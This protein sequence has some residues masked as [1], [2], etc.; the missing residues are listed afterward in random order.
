MPPRRA[1]SP[2]RSAAVAAAALSSPL[3]LPC[4]VVL[5]NRL[6]KAAMTEAL[7]D[8]LGR[9]TPELCRLYERWSA[10]GAGLLI[11]GNIQVDRRYVERPGNVAIDGG[12]N[13]L[14]GE[15]NYAD[16]M[17]RKYAASAKKHGSKVFAQLSHAGRQ[18]T[19]LI[20]RHP[21]GPGD[22]P[23]TH[24]GVPRAVAGLLLFGKPRALTAAE[25]EDVIERF[26]S[27]ARVCA[28][29]GF[30]GVQIHAAHGY[31]LSSFHNPLANNR[32]DIFGDDDP[33]GGTLENRA[34]V[35]LETVR[36]VRKTTRP[37]FAVSVKLNSADFQQGGF[38][39]DEAA[40]VAGWLEEAGCD[41][42]EVSGGTYESVA[43]V[44][45]DVSGLLRE[46]TKRR[47]GYFIDFAVA[48]QNRSARCR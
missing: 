31:L 5:P 37:G 48:V 17:L 23:T 42:L 38:T 2:A 43:M 3:K 16:H 44:G 45:S 10:G 27:A 9:A 13:L 18:S 36:A 41:L 25:V 24:Q 1:K 32:V 22:V 35:L 46:S 15:Q 40:Q 11:T 29:S 33:Y 14:S 34:R 39:T 21:V 26:A 6:A 28:D 20:N 19:A 12:Q 47:E 30:D 7:A 4:G 8:S